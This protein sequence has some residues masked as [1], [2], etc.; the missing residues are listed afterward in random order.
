MQTDLRIKLL[1]GHLKGNSLSDLHFLF[2]LANMLAI[3][4]L[5]RLASPFSLFVTRWSL[6]CY[7]NANQS[8]L[9]APTPVCA[10]GFHSRGSV[11]SW[12]YQLLRS[13]MLWL[14]NFTI[15]RALKR[16]GFVTVK[17]QLHQVFHFS[18]SKKGHYGAL[19]LY[20]QRLYCEEN[21]VKNL[22]R[23]NL[24]EFETLFIKEF[25]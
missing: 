17:A 6:H 16:Y 13:G 23:C 2:L 19:F 10:P 12:K 14:T 8:L 3:D 24:W 5:I 21:C 7:N 11:V 20:E 22:N 9:E 1:I 18:L 15:N 25:H 4:F